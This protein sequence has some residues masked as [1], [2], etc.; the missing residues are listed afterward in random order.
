[1][2]APEAFKTGQG[3]ST[4]PFL[5]RGSFGN[6]K[7]ILPHSLHYGLRGRF[8]AQTLTGQP[9]MFFDSGR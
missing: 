4:R 8:N 2:I 6:M 7:L 3:R 1:V 5:L 9:Q